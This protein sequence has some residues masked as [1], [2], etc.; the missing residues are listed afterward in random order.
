MPFYIFKRATDIVAGG[1][2]TIS[3]VDIGGKRASKVAAMF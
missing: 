1:M 2:T 3:P